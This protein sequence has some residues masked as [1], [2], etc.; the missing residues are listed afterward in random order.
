LPIARRIL[1]LKKKS[2]RIKGGWEVGFMWAG[3]SRIKHMSGEYTK[4]F[5]GIELKLRL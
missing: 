4:C 2:P 1:S 3:C 5:N